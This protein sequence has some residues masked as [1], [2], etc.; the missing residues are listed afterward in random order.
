MSIAR[1]S[2]LRSASIPSKKGY[3]G[4]LVLERGFDVFER[5][6]DRVNPKVRQGE[7]KGG[8]QA[9]AGW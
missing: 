3:G 2:L 4:Y 1:F 8:S 6:F 7:S 5:V 9:S